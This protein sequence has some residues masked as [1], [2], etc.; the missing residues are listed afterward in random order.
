M[1][2]KIGYDVRDP[3]V[4]YPKSLQVAHDRVMQLQKE[5]EMEELREAFCRRKAFL[6]PL[7]WEQDGILI[8]PVEDQKEL[9]A[10]GKALHHCVGTYAKKHGAGE[11]SILLI[12]RAE[13]PEVPWYTL[14]F[15]VK[16]G[17][18]TENRG[19]RNCDRTE[20]IKAFEQA[21]LE[22]IRP[23]LKKLQRAAKKGKEKVA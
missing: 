21:W 2:A 13:A 8:R 7:A 18:V 6:Q 5:K 10:E 16:T 11:C 15:N 3:A 9:I 12:R 14:N 4:I 17:T 19:S 20:E 22:H 1:G 23:I